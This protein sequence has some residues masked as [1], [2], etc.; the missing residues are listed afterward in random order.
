MASLPESISPVRGDEAHLDVMAHDLDVLRGL[1][2]WRNSPPAPIR[3]ASGVFALVEMPS[4][5]ALRTGRGRNRRSRRRSTDQPEPSDHH[6]THWQCIPF[7]WR[8]ARGCSASQRALL[9]LP[10]NGFR[11]ASSGSSAARLIRFTS[12]TSHRCDRSRPLAPPFPG[13]RERIRFPGEL[14]FFHAPPIARGTIRSSAPARSRAVDTRNHVGAD[15][16]QP[17]DRLLFTTASRNRT[18]A[19]RLF[20]PRIVVQQGVRESVI[21]PSTSARRTV[22]VRCFRPLAWWRTSASLI[23]TKPVFV[24][25]GCRWRRTRPHPEEP[26]LVQGADRYAAA[27]RCSQIGRHP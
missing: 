17:F 5:F 9:A 10:D 6:F 25:A 3:L 24:S 22:D 1:T 21:L 4:C 18:A 19:R 23:G 11:R 26:R 8:G 15:Q 13:C 27:A 2:F 14:G 16:P 20:D 7:C 12:R